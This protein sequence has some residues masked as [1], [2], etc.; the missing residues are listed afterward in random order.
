MNDSD[1]LDSMTDDVNAQASSC[2]ESA[3]PCVF[4]KALLARAA[5]CE[6]ARRRALAERDLIECP[7]PVARTNC[8]TLAALL[9]ERAR[10]V[11]RLPGP[12]QP[13]V[14]ARALHL[15]CGGL[16]ALQQALGAPRPD[17]HQMVGAAHE[18]HGSLIDLP[19]EAI[20]RALA[21]WQPRSR[22]HRPA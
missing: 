9:H 6:L 3:S 17:V 14:H 18:R 20:V 4:T 13:L 2:C 10:F 5:V 19:W 11:L 22:R 7:S 12:G 15:Q 21:Q 8:T 1:H 16:L